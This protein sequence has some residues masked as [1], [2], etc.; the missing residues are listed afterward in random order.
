MRRPAVPNAAGKAKNQ[1][2]GN[3]GE[4]DGFRRTQPPAA[5]PAKVATGF[6][7]GTC[8]INMPERI[9]GSNEG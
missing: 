6:A 4:R 3:T 2:Q 5:C 8:S 1:G 9:A 7:K